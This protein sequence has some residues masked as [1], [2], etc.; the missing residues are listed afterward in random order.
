MAADKFIRRVLTNVTIPA[1][2]RMNPKDVGDPLT[3]GFTI[4]LTLVF[5][6]EMS[7]QLFD[8]LA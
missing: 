8:G 4:R 2:Q 6:S 7:Q 5:F 3:S 1:P